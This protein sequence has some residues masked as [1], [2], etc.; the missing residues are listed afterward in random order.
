VGRDFHMPIE[1]H[2][3]S[4]RG[5]FDAPMLTRSTKASDQNF[6]FQE[7]Q[8]GGASIKRPCSWHTF[9]RRWRLPREKSQA[10]QH[11][12]SY[13]VTQWGLQRRAGGTLLYYQF[14]RKT[15]KDPST[16]RIIV[17]PWR[18]HALPRA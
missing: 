8:V 4:G 5:L 1:F 18:P 16:D 9:H 2:A 11:P 12:E 7:P 15:L 3:F 14:L 10:Q 6:R 17:A 13:A